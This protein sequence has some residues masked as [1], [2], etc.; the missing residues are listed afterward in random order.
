MLMSLGDTYILLPKLFSAVSF[1]KKIN[2]A[3]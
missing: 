2:D 3:F 1:V